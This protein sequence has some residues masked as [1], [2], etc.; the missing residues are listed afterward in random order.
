M[1]DEEERLPTNRK[2]GLTFSFIFFA[3]GIYS[4]FKYSEISVALIFF[5]LSQ[6]LI[7]I[8]VFIEK[9]LYPLNFF[10]FK[11]GVLIQKITSPL[12]LFLIFIVF[13]IPI[14]VIL[15]IFGLGALQRSSSK[16]ITNWISRESPNISDMRNQY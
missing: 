16:Q 9:I 13:I 1:K 12:V 8:S 2:F 4:Y 3:L 7:L 15:K 11:F 5:I 14:S 10:W 6:I